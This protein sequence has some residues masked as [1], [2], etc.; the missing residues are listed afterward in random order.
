MEQPNSPMPTDLKQPYLE[1]AIESWRFAK[2]FARVTTKMDLNEANRYSNQLRFFQKRLDDSL[3]A[4][5]MKIVNLEGQLYDPG[6]A[7]SPLNIADFGPD[8]KLMVDQMVEPLIMGPDG[9]V[10]SATV[11]L[12]LVS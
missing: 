7:A 5:D 4:I 10:K 11:M 12:T 6:M 8:D 1:L 9:I 2:L 3:L